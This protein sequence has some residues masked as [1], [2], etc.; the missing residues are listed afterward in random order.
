MDTDTDGDSFNVSLA[1]YTM[2]GIFTLSN[3]VLKRDHS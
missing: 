1:S 3:K 2:P